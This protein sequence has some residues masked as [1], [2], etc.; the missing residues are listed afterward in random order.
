MQLILLSEDDHTASLAC[1]GNI[2]QALVTRGGD[3]LE[4]LIGPAG[5]KRQVLLDLGKTGFIDSSGI[6]WLL[7][8]HR[9]FKEAGGRLILHSVPPMVDQVI[10]LLKL[11][12][13]L[14]IKP[15]MPE[16]LALAK[17]TKG[18]AA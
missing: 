14:T 4:E 18:Q 6:G 8:S 11:Q 10:Q 7:T 15:A 16:A 12:N 3:P 13:L 2:T 1:D 17:Q 5:F 9:S